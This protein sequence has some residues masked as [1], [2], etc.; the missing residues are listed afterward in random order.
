MVETGEGRTPRPKGPPVGC[1]TSLSDNFS[2]A[3]VSFYRQNRSGA[4]R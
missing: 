3:L 2:L 1:T 4:S